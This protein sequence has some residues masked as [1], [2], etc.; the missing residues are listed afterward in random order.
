MKATSHAPKVILYLEVLVWNLKTI[1]IES[2]FQKLNF[3]K[4]T[5]PCSSLIK[6][7]T[8]LRLFSYAQEGIFTYFLL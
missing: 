2:Q 6:L 7:V 8:L 3:I 5:P 4:K 1:L